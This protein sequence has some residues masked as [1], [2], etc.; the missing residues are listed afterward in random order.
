VTI[1]RVRRSVASFY[2]KYQGDT[3]VALVRDGV[4]TRGWMDAQTYGTI[5][6][7]D[8]RDWWWV[9]QDVETLKENGFSY[10]GNEVQYF[11]VKSGKEYHQM[12]DGSWE[13][14]DD[15]GPTS[16]TGEVEIIS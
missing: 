14:M 13:R 10:A 15:E 8:G 11:G 9:G 3:S 4:C 5:T 6:T 2:K 7:R 1:I 12:D 16:V